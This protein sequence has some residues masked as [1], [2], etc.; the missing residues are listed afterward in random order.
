MIKLLFESGLLWY[1]GFEMN[2][3]IAVTSP[4]LGLQSTA[5]NLVS[6]D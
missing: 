5:H 4:S 2:L 1:V 6:E 3:T